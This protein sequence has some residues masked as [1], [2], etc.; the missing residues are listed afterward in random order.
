M[1]DVIGGCQVVDLTDEGRTPDTSDVGDGIAGPVVEESEGQGK[2]R[3]SPLTF[4][5]A[6]RG[7]RKTGRRFPGPAGF[8]GEGEEDSVYQSPAWC[9]MMKEWNC[10][11]VARAHKK[12]CVVYQISELKDF[13]DGG[14]RLMQAPETIVSKKVHVSTRSLEEASE[15]LLTHW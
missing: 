3:K 11:E 7:P 4:P 5:W 15:V 2:R 8:V 6:K 10:N 12:N 14:V 9:Q 1:E 13:M